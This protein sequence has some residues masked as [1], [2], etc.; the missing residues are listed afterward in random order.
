MVGGD[1]RGGCAHEVR[2]D[3]LERR[4][5]VA[6]VERDHGEQAGEGGR[7]AQRMAR[8]EGVEGLAEQ[9]RGEAAGPLVE[10]A[11]DEA[12]VR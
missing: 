5:V 12:S 4:L 9:M 2:F 8:A 10:V 11:D 6:V 3:Q 7:Q 1:E